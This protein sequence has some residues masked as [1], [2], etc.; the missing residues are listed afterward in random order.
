MEE[1]TF[2][3]SHSAVFAAVTLMVF[4]QLC[5][6]K[7]EFRL[8]SLASPLTRPLQDRLQNLGWGSRLYRDFGFLYRDSGSIR[9]KAFLN[10]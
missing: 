8:G 4:F 6:L 3:A 9:L 1:Q 7:P 5:P 2:R 10:V